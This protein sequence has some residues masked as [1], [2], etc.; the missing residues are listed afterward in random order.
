MDNFKHIPVLLNESIEGLNIN[1]DG[2]YVDCTMGGAGHSSEILKRLTGKGRL[3]CFDQ[4]DYAI[5]KG[6]KRLSEIGE[7]YTIIKS[8]F[9]NIKS[10]LQKLNIEKVDGVLYDLGVSS[11][12]FDI[13][14]RGFSYNME[15]DLDM[16]MNTDQYLKA[17]DIVNFYSFDELKDIFYKYGEEKFSPL[18]AKKIVKERENKEIKTT[19][20]LA[21]IILSAVPSHVRRSGKHPAKKIFQALRIAV[22]DELNVFERSLNDALGMLNVGGRIAVITF[23]SLED[24]ICKTVF[25]NKVEVNIPA[26]IPILE[27]DIKRTFKLINNKVIVAGD[28]ELKDNNR[29]HSAKLRI[30]ERIAEGESSY[31]KF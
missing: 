28:D 19:T 12:Q 13:K 3:F 21:E 30:I 10:E 23:H 8:N 18:I 5:Q 25:K 4:D 15:G 9:V 29:S 17:Y 14:E 26:G 20:E 16:R 22:N 11:F 7:N 24:R 27:K 31:G 2:I 6:N 1:P